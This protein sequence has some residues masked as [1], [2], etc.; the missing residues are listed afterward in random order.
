MKIIHR[1]ILITLLHVLHHRRIEIGKL[2]LLH[3]ERHRQIVEGINM[4]IAQ[5][6][7]LDGGSRHFILG[8]L[9]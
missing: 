8:R 2:E 9:W 3:F 1:G 6:H 5:Y 4:M 7:G